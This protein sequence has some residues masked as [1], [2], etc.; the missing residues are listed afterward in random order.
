MTSS[1][2]QTKTQLFNGAKRK[3]CHYCNKLLTFDEATIDHLKPLSKGGY[4]RRRNK[5]IA[6]R[7]CNEAKGAMSPEEFYAHM[8]RK[9]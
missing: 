5:R 7:P 3:P 8:V 1:N 9:H 4:D 6:C 2:K